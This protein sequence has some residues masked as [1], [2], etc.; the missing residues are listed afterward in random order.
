VL[1]DDLPVELI[2]LDE[3]RPPQNELRK[4]LHAPRLSFLYRTYREGAALHFGG[5]LS[6]LDA[7]NEH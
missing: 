4:Q 3:V 2:E 1:G 6:F 7:H 5:V